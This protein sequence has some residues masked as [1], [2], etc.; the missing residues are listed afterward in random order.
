MPKEIDFNENLEPLN[1]VEDYYKKEK[2][3]HLVLQGEDTDPNAVHIGTFP[4]ENGVPGQIW[5]NT[6]DKSMYVLYD[7]GQ[8]L[9]WVRTTSDI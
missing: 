8:E 6:V 5:F 9:S 2:L 7:D 1:K 4:P 3:K